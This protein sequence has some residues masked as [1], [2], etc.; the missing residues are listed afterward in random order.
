MK[1]N[2]KS[3]LL[4][5]V[6]MVALG[7]TSCS[8]DD[9]FTATI[10]NSDPSIDY[11]DKTTFTFPLDTFCK[12]EFLEPYNL[13]FIYRMEDKASDMNKNLTPADYDK[14]VDL[15]V[16]TKYLWYDIYKDLAGVNF[17]KANSPRIIHVVGSK[18]YNPTQ[19]TETLGDASS[20]VKINLYNVNNLDASNIS[21]MNEYFFKTMHHEFTHILDQ[22]VVHP[23]TFNVISNG[24]YDA[25]GWSDASDS[26]KAGLGFVSAY[27]SSAVSEDWAETMAVYVTRDSVTWNNLLSSASYEWE[28][29]DCDS[30]AEYNK[31]LD[32]G[33]AD[34]DTVGYYKAAD[35]G[36]NKIVRRKCL[37][38]VNDNVVLG[39]D[40]KPQWVHDSGVEGRTVILKKLDLMRTYLKENFGLDID[41]LRESVQSKQYVKGTD[42]KYLFQ[43]YRVDSSTGEN[44]AVMVNNLVSVQSSGKTLI[45][46]LREWVNKY[47]ELQK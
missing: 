18:N 12:K 14:S 34:K 13:K 29:I 11:L 33:R 23:T 8:D 2:I 43:G 45:E 27:A 7:F 30:R 35:S 10:F 36:K 28:E 9:D 17:L 38:D 20:G 42:G 39:S 1:L 21:V 24:N 22:T 44:V 19:G 40:G 5:A 47:K 46:E 37:R 32:Q 16:L 3:L 41:A 25:A 26:I 4:A 31:K 15:A 6:G